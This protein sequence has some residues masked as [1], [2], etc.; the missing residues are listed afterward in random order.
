M[1]PTT[2][3]R[4]ILRGRTAEKIAT[5]ATAAAAS[6]AY[7]AML[8]STWARADD[9]P[10]MP[11]HQW[12]QSGFSRSYDACKYC[13]DYADGYQHAYAAAVCYTLAIPQDAL[14]G[15]ACD[16]QGLTVGVFGDRWLANGVILTAVLSESATPPTW[17][18]MLASGQHSEPLMAVVP[19]NTGIDSAVAADVTWTDTAA[20]AYVH[21]V[22]RLADYT[23]VR[24]AWIEGSALLDQASID[25]SFS[26]AV[27][28]D[29]GTGGSDSW[30]AVT[31]GGMDD[32]LDPRAANWTQTFLT[33]SA[34]RIAGAQSADE[35]RAVWS[36]V[37]AN[38]G[39]DMM[40]SVAPAD[41]G[42]AHAPG[43]FLQAAA[44]TE[45]VSLAAVR[46]FSVPPLLGPVLSL[47]LNLEIPLPPAGMQVG[48]AIYHI[49]GGGSRSAL[50]GV[51]AVTY[52]DTE[53]WRGCAD[54]VIIGGETLA[55]SAVAAGRVAQ[56]MPVVTTIPVAL[57]AA[58][59]PSL[60][61]LALHVADVQQ[62][63]G[64]EPLVMYGSALQ[65]TQ[66][67]LE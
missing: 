28:A 43:A 45:A 12:A 14:T 3:T 26:R 31:R 49:T 9:A 36:A 25:V 56:G 20:P 65:I 59:A 62:S 63:P 19:S 60:L 34:M 44:D 41:S 55:A 4:Y 11:P 40:S 30:L 18:E 52:R 6:Q 37:T 24:G 53:F 38:F 15:D 29:P 27:E 47:T 46:F 22:L 48:Y 66:I 51:D 13:G 54:A 67:T 5:T 32:P 8:L 35:Q 10:N 64:A 2:I 16:L 1:K 7:Y 57:P 42:G 58:A 21:L 17:A 50:Q 33:R 39:S 23:T 61:C